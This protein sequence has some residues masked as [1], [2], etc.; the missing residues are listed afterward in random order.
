MRF[1]HSGDIGDI[2][3][4]LPTIK[5]LGGGNVF[6]KT[7]TIDKPFKTKFNENSFK[8]IKPLLESQDYI[9]SVNIYNGEKIDYDLDIFRY[10]SDLSFTNLAEIYT[11]IFALDK[12]IINKKWLNVKANKKHP[13]II[14]KTNRYL[15]GGEDYNGIIETYG[16]ENCAFVGLESEYR[17]FIKKHKNIDYI[18]TNN[19]LELAQIIKGCSIFVGNQS[20]PY[21]IA[22]GLK[23][24][25][26][27]FI[28]S[29]CPNCIFERENVIKLKF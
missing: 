1:S 11:N 9:K 27:L 3:Y 28:C 2:I 16:K 23:K 22:E 18:Q 13:V 10:F 17:D 14:N 15:N 25:S 8:I 6:L 5:K 12:N 7:K 29:I 26:I 4:S 20:S 24:D 19:L 21:A